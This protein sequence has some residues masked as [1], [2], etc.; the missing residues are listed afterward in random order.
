MGG[1]VDAWA[2]RAHYFAAQEADIYLLLPQLGFVTDQSHW[3]MYF[4]KS[5]F[6]TSAADFSRIAEAMGVG[7][8]FQFGDQE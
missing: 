7:Q 3:G 1:E 2:R 6:K 4:R 5:L 8:H